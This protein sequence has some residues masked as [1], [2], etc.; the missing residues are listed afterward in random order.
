MNN[1][2]RKQTYIRDHQCQP[3]EHTLAVFYGLAKL[4]AESSETW[5]WTPQKKF[6]RLSTINN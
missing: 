2:H 5:N 6:T 3:N 1:S 4:L